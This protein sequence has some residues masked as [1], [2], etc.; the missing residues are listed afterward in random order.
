MKSV[1]VCYKNSQLESLAKNCFK[2]SNLKRSVLGILVAF[3][4]LP[5]HCFAQES[6]RPLSQLNFDSHFEAKKNKKKPLRK[7]D[8]S[9]FR[10]SS[11]RAGAS[12]IRTMSTNVNRARISPGTKVRDTGVISVYNTSQLSA[13]FQEEGVSSK[14]ASGAN[15]SV[16]NDSLV[17]TSTKISTPAKKTSQRTVR[18]VV[19]PGTQA[20]TT[21]AIDR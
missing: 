11:T 19:T 4:F 12:K 1:C 13:Q 5:G 10:S 21:G 17:G 14:S 2:N 6:S 3:L 18:R 8:S 20:L 9:T 7:L 15:I 16:V